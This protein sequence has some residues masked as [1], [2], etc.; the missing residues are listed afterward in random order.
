[1]VRKLP[2]DKFMS[3]TFL[4]VL[5][6]VIL[7]S[8]C[9]T[10]DTG[11]SVEPEKIS[12]EAIA[13][14]IDQNAKQFEWFAAKARV[15]YRDETR[16]R[17]FTA[18]IR[19]RK[20]SIIWASVTTLLGIEAARIMITKDSVFIVDRMGKQFF[21]RP[22]GYLDEYAPFS[23]ELGLLQNLL[24][25]NSLTDNDGDYRF[26]SKIDK[27]YYLLQKEDKNI[28]HLLWINPGNFSIS[29]EHLLDKQ[30]DRKLALIFSD[31]ETT[32]KGLFS[33]KRNIHFTGEKEV[34]IGLRFSRLIWNEPQTFP[35]HVPDKYEV[36]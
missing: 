3:D 17:D 29:T 23:F 30:A 24:I 33:N 4:L 13:D 35:F 10:L 12:R 15:S 36:H 20:D 27:G 11:V 31:Y 9:K 21:R 7:L 32:E 2:I 22:A 6:F 28:K 19:M 5:L 16:S 26:K 1:M 14:S 25:G 18:N 34:E 8:S